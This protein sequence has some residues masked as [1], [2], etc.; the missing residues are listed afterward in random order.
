M[1]WFI[2]TSLCMITVSVSYI[3]QYLMIIINLLIKLT[4]TGDENSKGG[5]EAARSPLEFPWFSVKKHSKRTKEE[6]AAP[7]FF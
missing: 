7:L 1:K 3:L 2:Y 6:T 4:T 5:I